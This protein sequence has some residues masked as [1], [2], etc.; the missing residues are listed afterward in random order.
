[1]VL[2]L[3]LTLT[4]ATAA[5]LSP[6]TAQTS[7]NVIYLNQAWSQDDREWY[8]H[9]SQ[10]SAILSYDIFLNLEVAGGQELFRS[11]ANS[12][13]YGLITEPQRSKYNPDGLPIGITKST[14]ATAV[15]DWPA[16]DYVGPTC[17]L[18]HQTQLNYKGKRIRIDGGAGNSFDFQAYI[19]ALNAAI[20]AT[21]TDAA[22]FDRLAARLGAASPEAKAALRERIERQ[23]P[24]IHQYATVSSASFSPWGPGIDADTM[25]NNRLTAILPGIPA[26]TS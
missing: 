24:A 4:L 23:A 8:Y 6:A 3:A 13:R 18:C 9:F 14:L 20:Q 21:L 25:I 12:E 15:G 5:G 17:A 26:N 19:K 11:N 1:M 7:D 2:S 22:K 10:G 16:G